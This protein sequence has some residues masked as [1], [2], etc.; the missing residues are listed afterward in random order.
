[1][2]CISS[3]DG[4]SEDVNHR[5]AEVKKAWGALKDVWKKSR[6]WIPCDIV[7]NLFA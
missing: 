4:M 3:E 1:M 2:P 5:I 6:E 7:P